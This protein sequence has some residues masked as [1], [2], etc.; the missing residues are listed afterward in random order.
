[1]SSNCVYRKISTIDEIQIQN[2]RSENKKVILVISDSFL[3][4]TICFYEFSCLQKLQY[5]YLSFS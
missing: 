2:Q 4:F 1:M 3:S 5:V